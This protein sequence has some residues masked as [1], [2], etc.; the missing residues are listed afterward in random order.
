MKPKEEFGIWF[1][2][3]STSF[4]T[5]SKNPFTI[6]ELPKFIKRLKQELYQENK[7]VF[8]DMIE[9]YLINNNHRIH[10]TL[11]PKKNLAIEK[12]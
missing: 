3:R 12:N 2:E 8:E 9:K 1:Y 6:L 4:I 7:K 5:H 11:K 10:M